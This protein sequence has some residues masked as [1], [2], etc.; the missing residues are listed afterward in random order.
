MKKT[1]KAGIFALIFG[2]AL[3]FTFTACDLDD[4]LRIPGTP[5]GLTA[6]AVSSSQINLYWN[7]V[8]GATGYFVYYSSAAYGSY[9]LIGTVTSPGATHSSLYSNTDYYYKVSAFNANGES[10]L[11]DY[12][13]ARTSGSSSGYSGIPS[14]AIPLDSG[15]WY[16]NYF[17]STTGEA[18]YSFYAY[19]GSTYYVWCLDY[20]Y[21]N[22]YFDAQI[23]AYYSDG[24][25]IFTGADSTYSGGRSFNASRSGTV[26]IR[27]YPRGS[28]YPATGNYRIAYSTSSSRPYIN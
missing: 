20:D 13:Y 2:I 22:S 17:Y 9:T 12:A 1:G 21:S 24:T 16:N 15:V 8:S 11:S 27:V 5:T 7:S 4:A 18:W 6:Y 26:Y 14:S 3:I 25:P 23:S 10:G 19:S 28:G